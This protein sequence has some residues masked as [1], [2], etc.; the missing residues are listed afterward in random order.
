MMILKTSLVKMVRETVKGMKKK[1]MLT[2]HA[3][4]EK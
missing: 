4:M 3:R 2:R 1:R